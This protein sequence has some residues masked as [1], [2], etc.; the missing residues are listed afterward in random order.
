LSGRT[1]TA[2]IIIFGTLWLGANLFE[3]VRFASAPGRGAIEE[4]GDYTQMLIPAAGFAGSLVIGDVAGAWQFMSGCLTPAVV[5]PTLQQPIDAPRPTGEPHSDPS[6][7]TAFAFQGAAFIQR[8]Y[9][10]K[11]G[12]LALLMAG[13]VGFSRLEAQKHWP[14]DVVVGAAIGVAAA[15]IFTRPLRHEDMLKKITPIK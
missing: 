11:L 10:W 3:Q 15:Y 13:Y 6:G 14:V 12:V 1:K 7:H 9:G 8:R 2:L 4:A 5:T